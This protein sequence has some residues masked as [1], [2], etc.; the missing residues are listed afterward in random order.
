MTPQ[1]GGAAREQTVGRCLYDGP[2]TEGADIFAPGFYHSA[3]VTPR[4]TS[5]VEPSAISGFVTA[6]DRKKISNPKAICDA[7]GV[8]MNMG[9]TPVAMS[10][11]Q[12]RTQYTMDHEC[13][14]DTGG[15]LWLSIS[16]REVCIDAWNR[17]APSEPLDRGML[18]PV[19]GRSGID[20]RTR[21]LHARVLD[22]RASLMVVATITWAREARRTAIHLRRRGPRPRQ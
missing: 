18:Q 15:S 11:L 6:P 4:E 16:R 19:P 3:A 8:P 1:I 5:R 9:R 10:E 13:E 2:R 17:A 7:D 21:G 12:E 14:T 22:E 20:G